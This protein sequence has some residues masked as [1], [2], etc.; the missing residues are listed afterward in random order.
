MQFCGENGI[1]TA[2]LGGEI[3]RIEPWGKDSLRVRATRFSKFT[4]QDWALIE[5]PEKCQAVVE[6]GEED[7]WVGDGTIDKKEIASITNGRIKA[8]VNFR[9]IITYY[10]D[11][12]QF[13]REYFRFYDGTLCK[14]SRCLKVV[15]REWKG[16]IG[17][18]EY[19]L[20]VKFESNDGE[21]I[22]GM[23]Q[24]QQPY[25]DLKGCVLELAQ[26]NSQIS[27]PFAVSSLG[28]GI[29]WNNPAIGE[30]TFGKNYTEWTARSTKQ[31]DYWLTVADG[32][33]QIVENYTAVTGRAPM[34][35]ED[36]M[37]LWQCKLRY[38]TQE[39][40]LSVARQYQKEGIK[41]D[42]IVK[43]RLIFIP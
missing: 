8:V 30:A 43:N 42:Q 32:P 16:V 2:R 1:L 31:M 40:V 23:G 26:R 13:L 3:L 39:E 38:R 34:F 19:Q 14:E 17:G 33:K 27:V 9:G 21:K 7:H 37:G 36:R 11:G 35:P 41:I 25:M 18:S 6:I 20:N 5:T 12:K 15:N 4:D 24:Y 29:L 22:F 28:Y 10:R